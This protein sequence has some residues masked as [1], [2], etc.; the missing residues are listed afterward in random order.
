MPTPDPSASPP[1]ADETLDAR[2]LRCPLPVLRARKM[3][4]A[5]RPGEVLAVVS[6]DPASMA[7]FRSFCGA[8]A[9]V[10]EAQRAEPA[11]GLYRHWLRRPEA[12]G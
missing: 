2:D 9:A 5:M 1:E 10:L 3:L 12:E 8:G 4:N 7:D 6:T 11:A